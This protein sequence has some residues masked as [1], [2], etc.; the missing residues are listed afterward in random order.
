M[1]K[2]QGEPSEK[3]ERRDGSSN[4]PGDLLQLLHSIVKPDTALFT[5]NNIALI[6]SLNPIHIDTLLPG[7]NCILFIILRARRAD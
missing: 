2:I 3:R 1:K 7:C 4:E 5:R 6:G